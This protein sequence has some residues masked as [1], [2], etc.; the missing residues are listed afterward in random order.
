M[1]GT[2]AILYFSSPDAVDVVAAIPQALTRTFHSF[3]FAKAIVP[4][5]ICLLLMNYLA[6]FNINFNVSSRLPMVAGWEHLLPAWFTRL[7]PKYGTPVNAI[8]FAGT[9]SVIASIG[10]LIGVVEQEAF[11]LLLVWA[12]AFYATAY[13]AL[14]AV[15]LLARKDLGIRPAMWLRAVA[16]SGF[17]VTL[18]YIVLSI[19]PIIELQD[20]VRYSIKTASVIL[21]ANVIGIALYWW[22]SRSR[23]DPATGNLPPFS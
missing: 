18:L 9:I 11:E 22:R 17:L 1:L 2:S 12:F 3:G 14:F 20:T 5:S 10:A 7:H 8:F 15:P 13:L 16:V 19:F 23:E 21:G 4:I 6:T